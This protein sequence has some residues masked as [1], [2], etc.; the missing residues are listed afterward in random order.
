M[1]AAQAKAAPKPPK[2]AETKKRAEDEAQPPPAESTPPAPSNFKPFSLSFRF[3]KEL[4]RVV[5]KVIDPET[6][7]LLREI[8]PEA[9]IDALK[10]LRKTPGALVD[11]EV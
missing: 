10:Q 1:D 8:P 6:G 11:E 7:E 9:V 4:N 5:V 3:E 2:P